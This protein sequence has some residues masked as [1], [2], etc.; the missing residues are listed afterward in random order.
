LKDHHKER[1]VMEQKLRVVVSKK[2]RSWGVE[3][4]ATFS[5]TQFCVAQFSASSEVKRRAATQQSATSEVLG[6]RGPTILEAF[7]FMGLFNFSYL[8][9]LN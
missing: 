4:S 7:I 3:S 2:L 6:G 1:I 8:I 9:R 5:Q